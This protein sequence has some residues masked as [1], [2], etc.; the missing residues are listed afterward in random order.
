MKTQHPELAAGRWKKISFMEQ[1][2]HIGSEVERTLKWQDKGNK[3]Y[4][5][6]A[7][8]RALELIDLTI[9]SQK[10]F[11]RIKELTRIRE[12]LVDYFMGENKYKSSDELWRKYFYAYTYAAR[13]HI[14][15]PS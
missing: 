8:E 13:I 11:P 1:L 4:A 15:K 10:S 12:L 9:A 3:D 14:S 2:A 6:F 5:Q 7:F